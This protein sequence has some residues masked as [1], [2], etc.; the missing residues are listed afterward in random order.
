MECGRLRPGW[1]R[2]ARAS[3]RGPDRSDS[4]RG[5]RPFLG[6]VIGPPLRGDRGPGVGLACP[7]VAGNMPHG[8]STSRPAAA[9]TAPPRRPRACGS[10]R[11]DRDDAAG[12]LA[13]ED[14]TRPED[15][16]PHRDDDLH[17]LQ[18]RQD[19][20]EV[21]HLQVGHQPRPVPPAVEQSRRSR[22]AGSRASGRGLPPRPGRERRIRGAPRRPPGGE[23]RI[24]GGRPRT[25]GRARS[26]PRP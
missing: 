6:L 17:A 4:R 2:P 14:L 9:G 24:P 16:L 21:L 19:F 11:R 20:V 7:A 22:R 25:P 1:T 15:R 18:V 3:P 5:L 26:R 13:D 10:P 23:P 12:G 8:E